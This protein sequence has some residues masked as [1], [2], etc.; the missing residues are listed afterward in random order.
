MSTD[1]SGCCNLFSSYCYC[2]VAQSCLTLCIPMGYSTLGFPVFHHLPN[3]LKLSSIKSVMPPNHLI[4][5]CPLLLLPSVFPSISVFSNE[6][7]FQNRWPK[8]WSFS[9]NISSSHKYSGLVSSERTGWI[10]LQSKGLSRVFSNTTVQKHQFFSIQLSLWSNSHIHT[11]L[12]EK[13]RMYT[14]SYYNVICQLYINSK[15]LK[16]IS[17]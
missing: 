2:S 9:F 11:W 12:L 14:W 3:L 4:L 7:V 13:S 16:Q 10:S 6:L 17:K 5:C 1:S 15:I 8:Y